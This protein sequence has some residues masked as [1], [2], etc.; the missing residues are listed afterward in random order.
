MTHKTGQF[1]AGSPA[2]A[3]GH[4]QLAPRV[5]DGAGNPSETRQASDIVGAAENR[6]V[7]YLESFG[8]ELKIGLL[9]ELSDGN[10]L[11]QCHVPAGFERT[12][13]RAPGGATLQVT[14]R[15]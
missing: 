4:L 3:N 1:A 5:V 10:G 9:A 13:K 8:T 2:Q 11:G 6:G 12:E 7:E 15:A 14:D